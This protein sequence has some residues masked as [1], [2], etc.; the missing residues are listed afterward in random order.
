M[1]FF[2]SET[3]PG[4]GLPFRGFAITLIGHT[5]LGMI[6]LD[7]R[8]ARQRDLYLTTHNIHKRQTSVPPAGFETT[9]PASK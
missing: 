4:Y 9:I 3:I 2:K 1:R 7:E 6:P 5:T 8:S